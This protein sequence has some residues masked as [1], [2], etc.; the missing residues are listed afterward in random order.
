[1]TRLQIQTRVRYNLREASASVWSDQEL[2]DQIYLAQRYVAT[3]LHESYLTELIQNQSVTLATADNVVDTDALPSDYIRVAGNGY[4]IT[5]DVI[6]ALKSPYEGR[7]L[8]AISSD[9]V[10]YSARFIWVEGTNL[11]IM[12]RKTSYSGDTLEYFCLCYPDDL[13]ADS[14]ESEINDSVIDLVIDYATS[15]SLIKTDIEASMSLEGRVHNRIQELNN[16]IR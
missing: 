4:N 11:N 1:M 7:R 14:T 9:D 13:S 2:Q 8:V 12:S 10:D 3:K 16:D 15:R 5:S 6:Y